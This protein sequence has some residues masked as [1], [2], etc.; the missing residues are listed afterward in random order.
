[1][2]TAAFV[3][4]SIIIVAL[5]LKGL[6]A[7]FPKMVNSTVPD[8]RLVYQWRVASA[9]LLILAGFSTLT[10]EL[11]IALLGTIVS[12]SDLAVFGACLKLALIVEYAVSLIHE[13]VA[14]DISDALARKQTPA[15]EAAALRANM[16]AIAATVGATVGFAIFGRLILGTF[17]PDFVRAYPILLILVGAQMIRAAFGPMVLTL[18]SAGSQ[19]S[20]VQVFSVAIVAY[21]LGNLWLVP[22]FGLIG[23]ALSFVAMTSIWTASLAFILKRKKGLRVDVGA[24]LGVLRRTPLSFASLIGGTT[25]SAPAHR[26][27]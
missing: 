8:R 21:G 18:I 6:V 16:A 3:A 26:G 24:S 12:K 5:Q 2:A 13:L 4:V 27:N 1:L 22:A 11:N 25:R 10:N 19:K 7:F 15:I 9:P 17:G 14:P 20:V 23:A